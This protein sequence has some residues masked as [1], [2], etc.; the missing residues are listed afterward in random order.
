MGKLYTVVGLA[1]A[2]IVLVGCAPAGPPAASPTT[3]MSTPTSTAPAPRGVDSK[4]SPFAFCD[5][6]FRDIA[7]PC[8]P[9]N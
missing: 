6:P 4:V 7:Q 1:L 9:S 8:I 2:G 5:D 3:K